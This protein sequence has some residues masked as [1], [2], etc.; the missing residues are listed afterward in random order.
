MVAKGAVTK[1][2]PGLQAVARRMGG[3]L[4]RGLCGSLMALALGTV[5]AVPPAQAQDGQIFKDWRIRCLTV[6]EGT[7]RSNCVAEFVALSSQN[8]R[9][10][11]L[12]RAHYGTPDGS[13]VAVII[14]PLLVRLPPG[15]RL[16]VDDGPAVT[17][18]FTV[19]AP[20]GCL[21]RLPLNAELLSAFKKGLGGQVVVQVPPGREVA[22][23]F[24]LRGFTA[25]LAAVKN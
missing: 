14:V 2:R 21:A 13:P 4:V 19:C 18:P 6:G 17:V 10:V 22:T 25:G 12:I 1:A 7:D 8:N 24:S 3:R 20:D 5:L 9:P 23:D 16:Q 15:L 11:L